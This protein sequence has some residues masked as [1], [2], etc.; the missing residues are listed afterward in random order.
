[1][2]PT[3]SGRKSAAIVVQIA[4]QGK[5]ED[6]GFLDDEE[7]LVDVETFV[8]VECLVWTSISTLIGSIEMLPEKSYRCAQTCRS[9]LQ[10]VLERLWDSAIV[11]I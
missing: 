3:K 10:S 9:L 11:G 8:D 1:M 7:T 4:G 6:V 2:Q 5:T